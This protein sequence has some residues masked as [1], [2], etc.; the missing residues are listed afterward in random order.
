MTN[1]ALTLVLSSAVLHAT[2]NFLAKRANGGTAFV[3]LFAL[4]S[5]II[6]FPLAIG[7]L[8]IQRPQLGPIEITFIIGSAVL[9]LGYFIALQQG[10]RVGDLS[11]IYP[12]ARGTGPTIST[13]AAIILFSERPTWVALGG[14]LFVVAGVF[15]L[16]SGSVSLQGRNSRQSIF[17]GLLTGLLIASYTLWDKYAVGVLL[18][19]PL[20]FDYG[21]NVGRI[22]IFAPYAYRHWDEIVTEWQTH[23]LEAIGVACFSPLAYIL[24]LTALA[25][26]PVS[27]V[28][29]VREISVLIVVIMGT[30]LLKEGQVVRR[31][32]AALLIIVGVIGLALN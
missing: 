27:Y 16:T 31:L 12:L 28:A 5:V 19:P 15:V 14:T 2:W 8:I 32:V 6:Y 22:L 9:H 20:L 25:F 26:T 13:V 29:P 30:G 17:F 23:R 10:Y 4:L 11:L 18:I 24:V 3:W 7:I 1:L 21:S